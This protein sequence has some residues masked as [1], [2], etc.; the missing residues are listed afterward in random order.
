MLENKLGITNQIKL[1]KAEE[2]IS[3][4]N[5]KKMYD[6]GDIN[7][8]DVG[9]YK[10]LADIHTYQYKMVPYFIQN[11]RIVILEEQRITTMGYEFAED[12]CTAT[13]HIRKLRHKKAACIVTVVRANY[14]W[15][16]Q[17]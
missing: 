7:K 1:A 16:G 6:S 17:V 14:K 15:E 2:R 12:N 3:K 10:G 4:T 11:Q 5:A 13:S 8:L 9:T